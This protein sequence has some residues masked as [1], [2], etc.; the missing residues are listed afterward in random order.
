MRRSPMLAS[1]TR[2]KLT[3]LLLVLQVA[4]TCA[5]VC[6]VASMIGHRTAQMRQPSG[7]AEDELVM[8]ES[9]TVDGAVRWFPILRWF[10]C[11]SGKPLRDDIR[12]L[13]D[14]AFP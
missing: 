7:V 1:L 12:E 13:P 3:V 10:Q 9:I 5:I 6:N 2:H 11:R 4:F 8:L 14:R